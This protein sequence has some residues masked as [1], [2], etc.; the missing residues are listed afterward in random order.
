MDSFGAE[1][2]PFDQAIAL[3]ASSRNIYTGRTSDDYQNMVG[4]FGGITAATLLNAVLQHP[5][6]I[7]E[8]VSM[9]VNFA[10]A[11]EPGEFDIEAVPIRTNRS[12]QHWQLTQKQSGQVVTIATVFCA[13]RSETWAEQELQAPSID[14][15]EE[16]ARLETA[17]RRAWL[18][19]YE[20]RFSS[21]VYDPDKPEE[22]LSSQSLLWVRDNP[23]RPLDF[24]A[25]AALGD[26][27]FPRL[28]TRTQRVFPAGT[29]SLT[30]HFHADSLELASVGSEYVLG[31]A[32]ANRAFRSYH[33]QTAYLWSSA[34]RLLLSSS[35][36]MYYKA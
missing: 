35:Q 2:H 27:F 13:V 19:N 29:V 18:A 16:L 28:F 20:F 22:G 4:P 3:V 24:P 34:G 17:H 30:L 8:P 5:G 26:S 14:K 6:R 32:R 1:A 36:M 7:G 9:T 21:G 23:S 12:T 10:A 33:D 11:I 15:P 25:L 31:S